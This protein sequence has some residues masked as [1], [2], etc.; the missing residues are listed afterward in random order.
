MQKCSL[1]QAIEFLTKLRSL[2]I[3]RSSLII[4][5]ADHGRGQHVKM[6]NEDRHLKGYPDLNYTAGCALP[7]M[8]IKVPNA[9][10]PLMISR[11][12]LR[13]SHS[14]PPQTAPGRVLMSA[15]ILRMN[16]A[17]ACLSKVIMS[18]G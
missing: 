14:A 9:E 16:T 3:Y 10:G 8:A 15:L 13:V 4:L 11:T 2:G 18:A 5:S 12:D 1:D 7:L 6:Q 17:L